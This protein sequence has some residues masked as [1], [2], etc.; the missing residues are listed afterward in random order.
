MRRRRSRRRRTARTRRGR[1]AGRARR[2]SIPAAT[3]GR[4][5]L[6]AWGGRAVHARRTAAIEKGGDGLQGAVLRVPRRRRPRRAGAGRSAA[7]TWRRA[8]AASPRVNGHRDYIIKALL[9]GLTGPVNGVTYTDVMIPMGQNR[10]E[11]IA[12]VASYVRNAFGNRA[13]MI[14]PADVA[15]VRAATAGR[16]DAV[17]GGGD[18]VVDAA[19][20]DGRQRPG[21]STASHNPATASDALTI[22][23]WTSGQRAAAGHVAAGRAA[24]AAHRDRTVAPPQA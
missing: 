24:A 8:L 2:S 3:A 14:T 5:G 9:H 18:R 1:A 20:G 22:R 13:S 19:H 23:P 17:D 11:W 7:G 16:Q 12:A 4:G 15:R 6:A 21:R 10:D